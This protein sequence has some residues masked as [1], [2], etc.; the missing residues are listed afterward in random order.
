MNFL[1][2]FIL[3]EN[4]YESKIDNLNC[5]GCE[6]LLSKDKETGGI[7]GRVLEDNGCW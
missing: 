4:N 7:P 2:L 1:C 3:F 5:N 6:Q